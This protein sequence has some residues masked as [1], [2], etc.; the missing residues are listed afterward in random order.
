MGGGNVLFNTQ[1]NNVAE[2]NLS[3][4]IDEMLATSIYPQ[5]ENFLEYNIGLLT[6]NFKFKFKFSG[7]NTYVNKDHRYKQAFE[8][9][10]KGVVCINKIANSLGMNIFELENE[11]D[12]TKGL[13]FTDKLMPMLNMYT[14]SGSIQDAKRPQKSESELTESGIATRSAGSN[15]SRGGEV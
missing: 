14:Q 8:S 11:L 2:T 9:A 10:T 4:S 15:L 13:K 1:K 12:M 3:L 7:T 6:K 5:F